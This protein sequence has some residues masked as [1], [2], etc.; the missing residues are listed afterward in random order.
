MSVLSKPILSFSL[1]LIAQTSFPQ[2]KNESFYAFKEDWSASP[3]IDLCTYFMHETKKS[4]TE[5]ICRYYNKSGPM[6]KQ[7]TYKDD[8]LSIPNGR[9]CWYNEKGKL[10][11]CG[12][13]INS[14]KDGNWYYYLG[15]STR[16]TYYDEYDNGKYLGRHGH[17]RSDSSAIDSTQKEATFKN[18]NTGWIKYLERNFIVPERLK[19][20]FGEGKYTVTICFTINKEGRPEDIYMAKS[21]E[22]SADTETIQLI[23]K[24]PAWN[25]AVQKGQ[26]VKYRQM[27]NIVYL[28]N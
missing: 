11:S 7:E 14:K 19:K 24:S 15:D 8:Q 25:P 26:P 2:S 5:Y 20:T 23:E 18:G 21:V 28:V 9:F 17:S 6:I 13:V 10:D 16:Y 22:W 3:S 1:L 27:Q 4:D 12:W